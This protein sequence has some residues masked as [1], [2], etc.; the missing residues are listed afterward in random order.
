MEEIVKTKEGAGQ[1]VE[2]HDTGIKEENAP[3]SV[4]GR[5][6]AVNGVKQ[7]PIK[8]KSSLV[9]RVLFRICFAIAVGFAVY[10]FMELKDGS[11]KESLRP[12]RGEVHKVDA[13]YEKFLDR[14]EYKWSVTEDFNAAM[15]L[16]SAYPV[17]KSI[18]YRFEGM[19]TIAKNI[20]KF[21]MT[22]SYDL[23]L[24]DGV[25]ILTIVNPKVDAF[26]IEGENDSG[27][28]RDVAT[29]VSSLFLRDVKTHPFKL[30]FTPT[31]IIGLT[32]A[33]IILK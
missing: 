9:G 18:K 15:Q 21:E 26:E 28:F 2:G 6:S 8:K 23:A 7:K 25:G 13:N 11:E 1:I 29:S 19:L 12:E 17:G 5:E 14:T 16:A 24:V 27:K 10:L 20:R 33:K 3:S 32:R 4:E 22:I 30:F 31:E